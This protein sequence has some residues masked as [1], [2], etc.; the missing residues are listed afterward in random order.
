MKL[1]WCTV[2]AQAAGTRWQQVLDGCVVSKVRLWARYLSARS[3]G[4]TCQC[5]LRLGLRSQWI[6]AGYWR[7]LVETVLD[8]RVMI[9]VPILQTPGLKIKQAREAR[10]MGS[11][12]QQPVPRCSVHSR[13]EAAPANEGHPVRVDV[14][15]LPIQNLVPPGC[16]HLPGHVI[17]ISTPR[18]WCQAW[19]RERRSLLLSLLASA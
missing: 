18:C 14:V 19:T 13:P 10:L 9:Q 4:R 15:K 11:H 6:E 8:H 5:L 1:T 2:Q 3:S 7:G 17:Y 12:V 16:R